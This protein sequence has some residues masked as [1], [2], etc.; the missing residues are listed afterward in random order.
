M[1]MVAYRRQDQLVDIKYYVQF[2]CPVQLTSSNTNVSFYFWSLS[3]CSK[4]EREYFYEAISITYLISFKAQVHMLSE[5][6]N[7]Y[8]LRLGTT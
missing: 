5:T 6:Y 1:K 2:S 7:N 3:I 4:F 8:E